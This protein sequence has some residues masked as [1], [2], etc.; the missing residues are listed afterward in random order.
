MAEETQNP[1]GP[2]LFGSRTPA[3]APPSRLPWIIAVSVVVIG[4]AVLLL[5]GRHNALPSHAVL[6]L[7]PYAGNV[8]FS[9][10]VP[11]ESTSISGGKSTYLDGHV[12]NIGPRT[13]TGATLQVLFLNDE[14]LPPQ[15]ETLPLTLIRTHVPYID[16]QPLSA[17]PLGP[18]EDREFRLIFENIRSNW[19]QALPQIHVV[20][21]KLR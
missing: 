10:L 4:L 18:G 13:L 19:N 8:V 20:S 9:V 17:A 2:E 1:S 15:V 14:A 3:P 21:A 7:D 6:P 5:A 11:S 16:T 12:R